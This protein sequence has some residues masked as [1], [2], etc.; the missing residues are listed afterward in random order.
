[1]SN[2]LNEDLDYKKPKK[3]I[4]ELV[5]NRKDIMEILDGHDEV[6]SEDIDELPINTR[7]KYITYNTVQNK[8]L[9]RYGGLVRK[10]HDDYIVLAGKNNKTFTVQRYNKKN[11][12]MEP[13]KFY[14]TH[15]IMGNKL[16]SN[17]NSINNKQY[18]LSLNSYKK[19]TNT[20]NIKPTD[21]KNSNNIK[22]V[23]FILK[24]TSI[25]ELLNK[26]F[27]LFININNTDNTIVVDKV[28]TILRNNSIK[29]KIQNKVYNDI[30]LSTELFNTIIVRYDL[31]KN[32]N[33][34]II[35][36][37]G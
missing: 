20:Y 5:Q 19:T 4:T 7:L 6:N 26:H 21:I 33:L 36:I 27:E 24:D 11:D 12:T 3:T 32:K 9:F 16:H 37:E 8:Y 31:P 14:K 17:I 10:I 25:M 2:R 23:Y 29:N 1:M 22:Y 34:Q 28:D 35:Y 18:L 15:S 30:K 13:T